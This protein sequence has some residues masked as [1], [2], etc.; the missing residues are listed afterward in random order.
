ME[1]HILLRAVQ[2]MPYL[3]D[4]GTMSAAY[5][6]ALFE[7]IPIAIVALDSHHRFAMCNPAFEELFQ[8]SP[9]ELH[10]ID[11][12]ELI[13]S[14]DKMLEARNLSNAV[15]R[16]EKV[17]MVTQRR[18]KD[19]M[20]LD[21]EIYGIPLLADGVLSGVYGIYQDVTERNHAQK[22]FRDLNDLLDKAQEEER[23]RVARDLHDSTAQELAVLNW[24]LTLLRKKVSNE[25]PELQELVNET[26]AIALQCSSRIRSATYLLHPPMLDDEGLPPVILR[27]TSEFEQRSGI[28]VTVDVPQ[29]LGRFADS[30]E[31]SIFRVV[32]EALANVLRHSGSPVAYVRLKQQRGCLRLDVRDEGKQVRDRTITQPGQ[33]RSGVGIL[34]MRERIEQ[35][36]GSLIVN[37]A[38]HGTIVSAILP[39]EQKIY[40]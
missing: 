23:R 22:A 19:G 21:V 8:F 15:L 29:E 33:Q 39:V 10:G 13:A 9:E 6:R 25:D 3:Y 2:E 37:V 34:G 28:R 16:G 35:L 26:K 11:T 38:E 20:M 32:Q 4:G 27:L 12:D 31:I 14:P 17:H 36:G 1:E 18:R 40:A 7:H 24:N 30:I 5:L